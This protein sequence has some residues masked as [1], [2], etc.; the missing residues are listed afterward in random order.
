MLQFSLAKT[1][2]KKYKLA[3]GAQAFAKFGRLLTDP[4]T[5]I[6]FPIKGELKTIHDYKN[7]GVND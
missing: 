1:L 5:D 3:S 4:D 2:A 7:T 6:S